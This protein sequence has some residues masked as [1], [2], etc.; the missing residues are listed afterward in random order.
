MLLRPSK[1][2][3][4]G[5]LAG[6]AFWLVSPT[7]IAAAA[8]E[9]AVDPPTTTG[10]S[11]VTVLE[12]AAPTAIDLFAAFADDIDADD[13]LLYTVESVSVG[14]LFTTAVDGNA[15]LLT[16]TY[17][18]NANGSAVVT[19][20]ATDTENLFVE[21]S[22]SV[23]L[24]PVNDAPGFTP[25]GNITV[26][27]DSGAQS[28]P[29]WA[30]GLAAGPDNEDQELT[31]T[32]GVGTPSLFSVQPAISSTGTLS[33]TPAP[34]ASGTSSITATLVDSEGT[35]NGGTNSSD[36]ETF[37]ITIVAQLDPPTTSGIGDVSVL[38]DAASTGI[39]LFA[40][41]QDPDDPDEALT[42]SVV[43]NSNPA[44]FANL[45]IDPAAGTLTLD[46][47]GNE[48][49][50]AVLTVR[51][52]DPTDLF[53]ETSFTVTVTAVNDAPFFTKGGDQSVG[54]D[55]GAQ[56]V[57]GWA[58]GIG[59]GPANEASQ[60][61]TFSTSA[62]NSALF[63]TQ[64]AVSA[65]GT[66]TYTPA[67]NLS[68]STTVTVTLGDTGGTANGGV[69]TSAPQTFQITISDTNDPPTTSGIA[70]V[71]VLEDAA[72]T[73]I[74]LFAAFADPEDAD[75]ALS[76]SVQANT[77]AA[78][79]A[80][81][82]ISAGTLTLD[83]A[84]DANGSASITVRATDTGG[85]SVETTFTVTVTPVNDAPS[86]TKG[87][88]QS[89]SEDGPPVS[90]AN[91]ASAISPGPANESAQTLTFSISNTNTGLFTQQP[92]LSPTGTLT[93]NVA[94]NVSG[95]AIVTVI[96][97]DNGGTANGGVASSAPQ[98]FTITV[99][100]V[101]DAPT[102][103]GIAN[104]QDLEDA[105]NRV[106]DLFAAFADTEDADNQL[107]YSVTANTNAALFSTTTVNGTAG[108][109]TLDYAP[110]AFGSANLTVRATDTGGLFVETTF[111]VAVAAVNDA[112]SFVKGANQSVAEDSGA[113]QVAGWATGISVGPANEVGQTVSFLVSTP[114][115]ALFSA[116]PA[117]TSAGVLSYTPAPS[118]SGT[119]TVT[120]VLQDNGGVTNGGVDQSTAQTFTITIT[121]VNDVPVAVNDAYTVTEGQSLIAAAGGSPPGVLDND[122]DP[123]GQTLT[124]TVIQPPQYAST[125][126]FNTNGSFVYVHDGSENTVDTITYVA[127]DGTATS[128]VATVTLTI[129]EINDPPTTSGI[130]GIT[131]VE[132]AADT[133][134]SL[135]DSFSDPDDADNTLVYSVQANTNAALFESTAI[136]ASTGSLTLN[137]AP[138]ANG[139]AS[140]TV[141]ATDPGGLFI[142]ATFTVTVT[143]VNDAP[144]MT[145][146]DNI[147]I[148]EDEGPQSFPNWATGIAAGPSDEAVQTVSVS[149]TNDNPA[150][151]VV[152]PTLTINGANGTITFTPADNA[153]GVATVTIL[154]SDNGGTVN[155]GANTATYTFTIA[156]NS[157]NDPP[158]AVAVPDST[159]LEDAAPIDYNLYT[160]F[161]DEE[162]ADDQLVFSIEGEVDSTLFDTFTIAGNPALLTITLLAD[163]SG[164]GSITVRATDTGGL[165]KQE[166]IGL[167]VLPVNDAPTF[168]A[169]PDQALPQNA[170]LQSVPGWATDISAGPENETDQT[171][172]FQLTTDN[173]ALFVA[174]PDISADGT[175]T[176]APAPGDDVF[177]VATVTVT[178]D[179][180]GTTNGGKDASEAQTFQITIDRF[181]T[182]PNASEDNYLV[183][184]GATLT[185]PAVAGVLANDADAE[186][187]PLTARLVSPPNN[188]AT[189]VL[190][191]DGSFSYRHD[192]SQTVGDSFTYA[193]FD[194]IDESDPTTVFIA[195]TPSGTLSLPEIVVLE[196]AGDT[197]IDLRPAFA[198]QFPEGS[199]LHYSLV[200]D[201]VP[202]FFREIAIDSLAGT[203]ILS[204]ATN[205]NGLASLSF[206]ATTDGG[207]PRIASVT[208]TVL[209]INDSP[210]A[211]DDIAAT[212]ENEPVL[213]NVLANDV[214]PDGDDLLI[215]SFSSPDVGTVQPGIDGTFLYNPPADFTGRA[216]FSYTV[217]DDSSATDRATV[218]ITV[219]AGRFDIVDIGRATDD[220][221]AAFGI[222]N[223]GEI[224]GTSLLAGAPTQAFSSEQALET[225]AAST[226]YDVN[227]FGAAV[228]A[229]VFD[230]FLLAA[231]WDSLGLTRLGAFDDR[232]SLAYGIN[233][234]GRIVGASTRAQSDVLQA[235]LWKEGRLHALQTAEGVES[236]AFDISERGLAAG[237][238]GP[239]AVLWDDV[240]VARTL[241]GAEGRAYALNE[242]DQAVGSIDDGV[243]KAAF[244]ERN[245][246]L[247]VIHDPASVFSEAYGINNSTWVVG[248]YQPAVAGKTGAA[249]SRRMAIQTSETLR[250]SAVDSLGKR[251]AEESGATTV[252]VASENRAFLWRNGVQVD[253]NDFIDAASG[254][255]L[256]EALGINNAAQIVGYGLYNGRK[257]AF[258]LS[259]SNNAAPKAADDAIR[260]AFVERMEIDV[261][262]N[263]RDED[264]DSLVVASVTQGAFGAVGLTSAGRAVYTPGPAFDGEDAFT[265]VVSDGRG[266][267]GEA[268]VLITM[269][270]EARPA[271]FALEPNYPNPFNPSTTIT[272]ALP[273]ASHVVLEVFNLIGQRVDT[274]IDAPRPAGSHR[275]VFE[276]GALPGGVYLYR[277]RAGDFT[278]SRK[279]LLLK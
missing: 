277:L 191:P 228:G 154:L 24:T 98:T 206:R 146:G 128:N 230:G 10:I 236:Q 175:L 116:Q 177:G 148:G 99:S 33:F 251:G 103:S 227:D 131:V 91:W 7:E 22:F 63:S 180:G 144:T 43:G 59:A 52:T 65:A 248:A 119:A 104:V 37:S 48:N 267:Q 120:V 78:L 29:N 90:V 213:V 50:S 151:F 41:F 137:Y 88:D 81:A 18:P 215:Q 129:R 44:L 204:Y 21:T 126:S 141:R 1:T 273:E 219:F 79:F 26:N 173:D 158:T 184:Q 220:V 257:R 237:Y 85:Q 159:V 6:V 145:P 55:A 208:V 163:A 156:V 160:I 124:A 12:D 152:Q 168:T 132:D 46:Y 258:L 77:N 149:L 110:D 246:A 199:I 170:P 118:T 259:P 86:F 182:A 274:L 61:L 71:T 89:P 166:T 72:T 9:R 121:G 252:A 167:T 74:D 189:F 262:A 28:F 242:S 69:D 92:A 193:A 100:N 254:W 73:G 235:F 32:L 172:D 140:L 106:V 13:A 84:A 47:A 279:L 210:I 198:A 80:S 162:D 222:S 201:P 23:T 3:L 4:S 150:L 54:E 51:A 94:N 49:G 233:N 202:T 136:N 185:V 76:Y 147:S 241:A 205:Q 155:G 186:A 123:D 231:R 108:S 239:S 196:D 263:D 153:G 276:A 83:Y 268:R 40:A 105:A 165:W 164:D 113:Q 174:L 19:L 217:V 238:A 139:A 250:T 16:L 133:V 203:V 226:A 255:T 31:F 34:G 53:V 260:L 232:S 270:P 20:R 36:Q 272:F 212:I 178:L 188:A 95:T 62:A 161:G 216:T 176:Y 68:G 269:A 169:G 245:G 57:A 181:N 247:Q 157:D 117:I 224:V 127:S 244:W 265:Y 93:Y 271:A 14:G 58:S 17:L 107:T 200:T 211:V 96:L 264:G 42:F 234:A 60:T 15:G 39:D 27:E 125:W 197:T 82:A 112:P 266:G 11:D 56:T 70:N 218:T 25:G 130:T 66:L 87:P 97:S 38:E 256:V 278:A 249:T 109:L 221:S 209:P 102:S 135:F 115:T 67:P 134:I 253:L 225:S 214:D 142:Q 192:N 194:G 240:T 2:F 261:L 138:D 111:S 187:D 171:I 195:I 183:R 243:V 143:A 275:I 223:I 5:I 64:P 30:T 114:S 179:D 122:I 75:N 101:N 190:N 35:A 45:P 207:T 229:H 8:R